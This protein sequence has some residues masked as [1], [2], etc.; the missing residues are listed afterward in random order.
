M[1]RG[2]Q[3]PVKL[4]KLRT[5]SPRRPAGANTRALTQRQ[6][7]KPAEIKSFTPTGKPR[8]IESRRTKREALMAAARQYGWRGKTYHSAQ[9]YERHLERIIKTIK[10][11]T[12]RHQG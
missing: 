1:R 8:A 12:G 7:Y 9:K 2:H 11:T 3:K 10:T 5:C 6:L 4:G